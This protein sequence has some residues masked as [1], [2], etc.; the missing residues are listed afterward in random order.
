[1]KIPRLLAA[2]SLAAATSLLASTGVNAVENAPDNEP[3]STTEVVDL[4]GGVLEI[5]PAEPGSQDMIDA[6]AEVGTI[7]P[8]FAAPRSASGIGYVSAFT[9]SAQGIPVPIPAGGLFHSIVGTKLFIDSE[10]ASFSSSR[11]LI[12]PWTVSLCDVKINWQTRNSEGVILKTYPG[13]TK[14]GC[15]KNFVPSRTDY[16]DRNL[17]N[18][19]RQCAV[20]YVGGK[21]RGDQCHRIEG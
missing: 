15:F 2:I 20:L 13:A 21:I 18:G 5:E 4:G 14:V 16:T 9:I 19:Q 6:Q 8:K 17:K 7:A 3:G 11:S 12:S 10:S 1:M